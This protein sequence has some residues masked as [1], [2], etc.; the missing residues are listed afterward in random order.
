VLPTVLSVDEVREY[1]R[2]SELPFTAEEAAALD[3]LRTRN[4]DHVDRYEMPLKSSV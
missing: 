3:E 2:A 4:F 1:A